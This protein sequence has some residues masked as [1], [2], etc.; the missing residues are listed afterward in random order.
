MKENNL[1][2][3]IFLRIKWKFDN[4]VYK[5]IYFYKKLKLR[6]EKRKIIKKVDKID[7]SLLL[8]I[9]RQKILKNVKSKIK[10]PTEQRH[11][12]FNYLQ[13]NCR[14]DIDLSG[15]RDKDDFINR[16]N[17]IHLKEIINVYYEG[18]IHGL[19][20][21]GIDEIYDCEDI[22]ILENTSH[23]F[24]FTEYMLIL[25]PNSDFFDFLKLIKK[26]ESNG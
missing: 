5:A 13:T 6:K 4:L 14:L 26:G 8:D 1:L 22:A 2:S 10:D 25:Y 23:F 3:K 16:L 20:M 21:N 19:Y 15:I 18:K 24:D 9:F 17:K 11:F 12:T 7:I